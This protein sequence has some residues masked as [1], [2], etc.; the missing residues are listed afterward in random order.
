MAWIREAEITHE[1]E[2]RVV[3]DVA[4]EMQPRFMVPEGAPDDVIRLIIH[5]AERAYE[6]GKRHARYEIQR[7][8]RQ[9]LGVGF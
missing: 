9:L 4:D 1:N 3:R 8:L 2:M 6:D 5:V 7:E